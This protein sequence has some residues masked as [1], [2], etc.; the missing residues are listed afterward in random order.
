MKNKKIASLLVAG[1]LTVSIV[2]GTLAW[3]VASDTVTN[4]FDTT[5]VTGKQV[6][7]IYEKFNAEEAKNL[8]PNAKIDKK[9][10]VKNVSGVNSFIRV[11]APV[12]QDGEGNVVANTTVELNYADNAIG[13]E[14]GKW[15]LSGG[16][17]YYMGIVEPG[18]FTN[19]LLDNF[20]ILQA[21]EGETQ[22]PMNGQ[23]HI[24]IIADSV[25][26]S[27]DAYLDAWKDVPQD[28]KERLASLQAE[29]TVH[30]GLVILDAEPTK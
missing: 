10:Q 12:V 20:K 7:D 22:V 8:Y 14:N 4:K 1:A 15:L 3:L 23:Y 17:Y 5:N 2:G 27:N 19:Q 25:Q 13:S 16:Y 21:K 28:V 29:Q 24:D 11:K 6:I 30:N 18:M 9:V 26:S